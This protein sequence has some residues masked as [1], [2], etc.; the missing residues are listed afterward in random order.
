MSKL[1]DLQP[2]TAIR[3]ILPGALIKEVYSLLL[4]PRGKIRYSRAVPEE[5]T[6]GLLTLFVAGI[7]RKFSFIRGELYFIFSSNKGELTQ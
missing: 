7:S 3:G 5:K 6:E 2:N 4:R 1:E